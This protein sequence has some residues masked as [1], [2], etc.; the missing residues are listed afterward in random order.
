MAFGTF[1]LLHS[2]HHFYLEQ[3]KKLGGRLVVVV[4]RD[5]NVES[6][7]GKLPLNNEN[8][9]LALVKHLSFVDEAVLGDR[10]MRKW[11]VV[12]RFHPTKIALGYDQWVGI[13]SL[14]KELAKIGLNP[15][16]VRIKAF[17]PKKNK[18]SVLKKLQPS[19]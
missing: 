1:D 6:L 13:P 16:I 7:K 18:S 14:R 4:A 11:A 19:F 17:K 3:A 12:K 8:D 10:E 15:E 9:R 2:G 5:K